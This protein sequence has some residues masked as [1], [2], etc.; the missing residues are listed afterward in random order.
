MGLPDGADGVG[1]QGAELADAH[2]G[3][4]EHLDDQSAERVQSSGRLHERRRGVVIEELGQW[5]VELG[6]IGAEDR[7]AQRGVGMVPLDEPFEDDPQ[8]AEAQAD[9][10]LLQ[11]LAIGV[12]AVGEPQLVGLDVA[13]VHAAQRR[14]L[15][16]HGR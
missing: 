16:G 3:A 10:R 6:E 4:G 9:R 14:R 1:L 15:S 11:L 7:V 5:F 2:A 13:P 12:L 8:H